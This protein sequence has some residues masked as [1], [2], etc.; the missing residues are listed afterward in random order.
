MTQLTLSFLIYSYHPYG[1]QQRDF[2]RVVEQ[3][4]QRG[5]KVNVYTMKWQGERPDGVNIT[6]L[7]VSALFN[8]T[9][10]RRFTAR[11][12]Q[13]LA[14]NPAD[15]VVGFNKMPGLDVYFAADPCFAERALNHRGTYYRYTPRFHHFMAY[16]NAVFGTRSNTR[17]LILSPLQRQ[18]FSRH[19]P[20]C[21]ARLY[22]LP[23]GIGQDRRAPA[24]AAQI[25]AQV[26]Q[27]FSLT[28][29]D[30]LVLHVGSGFVVKGV[31]RAL[32]AIASLPDK[33]RART[34]YMVVGQDKPVRFKALAMGLGI[35]DRVLFLGGRDDVPRF[36]LA[37]D[38]LLHPAYSES[39]GYVLLEATVAGLPVLATDTCG[40]A[41]HIE[42]AG[43]GQVCAS[44]FAQQDLDQ[45]LLEMLISPQRQQWVENGLHYAETADL[46]SMPETAA[47][48]IEQFAR[49]AA[50]NAVS[51]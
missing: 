9:L 23:P 43:S 49:E 47:S 39:A 12:Q 46:Y 20:G 14:E 21:E 30:H 2:L 10:Y 13:V 6:V 50:G 8:H 11:V 26:R 35:S 1:G 16:E 28:E 3:C 24:N 29:Q 40:Y 15:V 38:L 37:A 33:I 31:D 18:Q 17:P 4:V 41:F 45:R 27:E 22:D 44:P 5:H 34:T 7:P 25:R 19:Y 51:A 32:R 48:L 36:L 42:Q